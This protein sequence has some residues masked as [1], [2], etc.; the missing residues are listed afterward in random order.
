MAYLASYEQELTALGDLLPQTSRP[1]LITWGRDDAFVLLE[2][3][4]RLNELLPSSELV[5]F[6]EAGHYSHEDAGDRYVE[7]LTAWIDGGYR[8]AGAGTAPSSPL[9]TN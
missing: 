2:N 5:V 9:A 1:V 6:D 4:E 7:V 8:T 3:G